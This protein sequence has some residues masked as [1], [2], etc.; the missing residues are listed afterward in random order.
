[1]TDPLNK[2]I[3]DEIVQLYHPGTEIKTKVS[4]KYDWVTIEGRGIGIGLDFIVG[5]SGTPFM[6]AGWSIRDFV[7]AYETS[8]FKGWRFVTDSKYV[9]GRIKQDC[10][11]INQIL[12]DHSVPRPT[13]TEMFKY[14]YSD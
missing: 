8:A 14:Y 13:P 2:N 1:M 7:R 4:I 11:D 10:P 9:R 6:G 12:A 3:S 5:N